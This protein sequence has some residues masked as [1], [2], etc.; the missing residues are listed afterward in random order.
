VNKDVITMREV[1]EGVKSATQELTRQNIQL[2]DP[3][4]LQR[5][6]LQR[7]IMEDLQRQEAKRLNIRVDDPQVD[8]AIG[9]VAQRNK[10]S[11]DQLHQAIEKQGIG[12]QAY[13]KSIRNEILADRLRQR[14]V[15]GN[16]VVSDSEVDAFLKEQQ[17]RQGA[18]GAA[19]PG[20]SGAAAPGA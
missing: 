2:P 3:S 5:Q 11:V 13:R 6:V 7:L 9:T 1:N 15:D 19:A 18:A 17:R 10:M 8:Q 4:V 20:A 12:W 14:T 16:V